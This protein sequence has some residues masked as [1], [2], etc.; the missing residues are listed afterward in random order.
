MSERQQDPRA[1]AVGAVWLRLL[2]R[3]LAAMF[4]FAALCA[5]VATATAQVE[6]GGRPC[7]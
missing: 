6:H 7:E 3:E 1:T 2:P 4:R 5:L